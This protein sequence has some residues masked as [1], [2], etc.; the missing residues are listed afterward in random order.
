MPVIRTMRSFGKRSEPR[1]RKCAKTAGALHRAPAKQN[2]CNLFRF[3]WAVTFNY[4]LMN[5]AFVINCERGAR[6]ISFELA[7][8]DASNMVMAMDA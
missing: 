2:H 4:C 1:G 6:V 3:V 5:F 7:E 8:R